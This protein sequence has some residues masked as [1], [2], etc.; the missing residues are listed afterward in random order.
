MYA[1]VCVHA[2]VFVCVLEFLLLF[3]SFFLLLFFLLLFCR[4]GGGGGGSVNC[5]GYITQNKRVHRVAQEAYVLHETNRQTT[6]SEETR[7][8]TFDGK[9]K[10]DTNVTIYCQVTRLLRKERVKNVMQY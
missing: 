5:V 8:R 6:R 10:K 9:R 1:C 4:G 7:R 2:Y 3:S